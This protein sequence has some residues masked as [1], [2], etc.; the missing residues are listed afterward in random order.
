MRYFTSG[1]FLTPLDDVGLLRG[2]RYENAFPCGTIAGQSFTFILFS[3]DEY[4]DSKGEH[5]ESFDMSALSADEIASIPFLAKALSGQEIQPA[6][7][8]PLAPS[9]VQCIM[10]SLGQGLTPY[11][12]VMTHVARLIPEYVGMTYQEC[13]DRGF[14]VMVETTV[15]GVTT[16]DPN[17]WRCSQE[18]D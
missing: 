11:D 2:V 9:A 13:I 4:P 17:I 1:Y 8:A 3:P 7:L 6:D 14:L 12:A 5:Q 16:S 15:D 18:H 10:E